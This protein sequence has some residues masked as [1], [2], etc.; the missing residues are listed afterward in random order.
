MNEITPFENIKRTLEE[1]VPSELIENLPNKWEKIGDVVII[2]LSDKLR[3]YAEEIGKAYAHVLSCKT[4]LNDVGGISG[5]QRTPN[6]ERVYGSSMTETI[7]KENRIRFLLDP[8]KIMFSSGNIDERK[9]MATISNQ[10]EIVVDLFAGI[11]YF[12]VPMAVYSKPVKIIA[13]E[14]NPVSY[15]YLCKNIV[16]NH[17]TERV[18]PR[19]GDSRKVAPQ[20]IADRVLMGY[21][22]GTHQ[23]LPTAITC[24]K[25]HRG[26]I[27]YH[28]TFPDESI[29]NM[30]LSYVKNAARKFE[31][32][33][34]LLR[35]KRVKTYAPGIS[36]Y[37]FDVE[38]W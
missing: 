18:E 10:N 30:P 38:I 6:V 22:G 29:P 24:L 16:L 9:R 21:I 4:V 36:H 14:I 7:H 23:F 1:S 13:C 32:K 11:G 12:S 17:V 25:N 37:V 26:V 8:M 34:K 15:Y 19:L 31:R 27:H 3:E 5:T 28:D 20:Q 33:E 2:K 35:Y